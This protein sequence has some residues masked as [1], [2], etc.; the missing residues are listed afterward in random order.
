[1][2]GFTDGW[3]DSLIDSLIRWMDGL[4][5][6]LVWDNRQTSDRQKYRAYIFTN[7]IAVAL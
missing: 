3:I 4:K 5:D 1:M 6:G 2:D 7:P